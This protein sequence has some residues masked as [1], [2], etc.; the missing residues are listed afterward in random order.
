MELYLHS[1][2][3]PSWRDAQLKHKDNFIFKKMFWV[4]FCEDYEVTIL[5]SIVAAL[6]RWIRKILEKLILTQRVNKLSA[7]YGTR[8]FVTVFKRTRQCRGP[9]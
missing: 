9:L 4:P 1:P 2:S 5:F 6:T 3:T 7:L 8:N